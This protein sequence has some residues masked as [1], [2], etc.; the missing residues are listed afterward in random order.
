MN[1][2]G[3]DVVIGNPP[4]RE[5][6]TVT[7]YSIRGFSCIATGNLYSVVMERCIQLSRS[8][9]R[10]G[11]IVPVSSIST[12]AHK[13][14]QDIVFG[15]S[16]YFSSYDD[17]PSRLF[18][19][20]QH[21]R[22]AIHLIRRATTPPPSCH[23]TEYHRWYSSE[24][25]TL[26]SLLSYQQIERHYL[27]GCLP[28]ISRQVENSIL[29][30]VWGDRTPLQVWPNV[31]R[32]A[33]Y[34]SRKIGNFLQALNF[35]PEV[36]DGKGNARNPTELKQLRF[37]SDVHAALV[38]CLLNS[39]L[40]RW[41]VNVFSDCRHLNKREIDGFRIDI[42]RA[43]SDDGAGSFWLDISERLTAQLRDTA[44]HRTMNFKHD[45]LRVQCI[46]PKFSK[47]IIDE[48]D[49][50]LARHYGFTDEELDFVMNY[51]IKYRMG[52]LVGRH[53]P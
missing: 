44:E 12:K 47:S 2:G 1:K 39:S 45:R 22:L 52:T 41:F 8:E 26:F 19:G 10:V 32:Y 11:Q 36:Y 37:S 23:V 24:R 21:V 35:V 5:L 18:D 16:G 34:Y 30:K 48:V 29:H 31:G 15:Y 6:R 49:R 42:G 14:L 51:D 28:K 3:F 50:A 20:L 7:E 27:D 46:I 38:V 17:R 9:A 33:V 13:L 40:F 53:E 43:L 4:Y 25:K